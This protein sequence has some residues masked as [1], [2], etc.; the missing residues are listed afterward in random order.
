VVAPCGRQCLDFRVR[1]AG[2]AVPTAAEEPS[3]VDHHGADRR[4]G[5]SP[6]DALAG[7]RKRQFHPAGILGKA[8]FHAPNVTPGRFRSKRG[9]GG[10]P[11]ANL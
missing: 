8:A 5:R 2:T 11:P 1:Q 9:N 7:F 10:C 6:A 4:I 3:V